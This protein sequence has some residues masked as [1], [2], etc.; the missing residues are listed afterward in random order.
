[1]KQIKHFINLTNGIESLDRLNLD[2]ENV[3]FIR[4]QSSHCE[5][6]L[7]NRIIM[8]TDHNLYMMLALGHECRVYDFGTNTEMAK[9]IYMGVEWLKFALN[10]RW[11]GKDYKPLAKGRNITSYFTQEY[12]K[13]DKHAKK[14]I[15]YFK[16]FLLCDEL[17]LIGIS[18][19]TNM[20]AKNGYFRSILT[21]H[22]D[23]ISTKG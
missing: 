9:A 16:K 21:K 17:R 8:E 22:F 19:E 15:D 18:D 14:K 20:D 4:I 12:G 13:L 5:R 6:H 7:W 11:F 10:K 1:M 23:E 2:P 3:M